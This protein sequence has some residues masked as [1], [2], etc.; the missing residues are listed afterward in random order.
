MIGGIR[1]VIPKLGS[2]ALDRDV[3]RVRSVTGDAKLGG[4]RAELGEKGGGVTAS[5]PRK[6]EHENVRKRVA[7]RAPPAAPARATFCGRAGRR[8]GGLALCTTAGASSAGSEYPATVT[9]SSQARV[10]ARSQEH[11]QA[12]HVN[13]KPSL[14]LASSS[15]FLRSSHRR[16]TLHLAP[17]SFHIPATVPVHICARRSLACDLSSADAS[18]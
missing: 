11:R 7:G 9:K 10:F 8:R 4:R 15:V 17:S 6:S 13:L 1:P 2:V 18:G 16:D 12:W 5:R 14:I 3:L